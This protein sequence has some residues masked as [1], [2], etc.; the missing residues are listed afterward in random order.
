MPSFTASNSSPA[1]DAAPI[2]PSD[3]TDLAVGA[4][5]LYVGGTGDITGITRGGAT[6]TFKNVAV[7]IFPVSFRRILATGTTATFIIGLY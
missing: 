5:A 1:E 6:V 3:S 4:R 7:G 2:T